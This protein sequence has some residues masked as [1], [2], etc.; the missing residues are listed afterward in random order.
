[1]VSKAS[2]CPGGTRPGRGCHRDTQSWPPDPPCPESPR[3]P[4]HPPACAPP[5]SLAP[6]QP[7]ADVLHSQ[8]Q[9]E[10]AHVEAAH[11]WW[12]SS[13]QA[14]PGERV[15]GSPRTAV[16]ELRVGSP[17]RA[18]QERV[19][20]TASVR[21]LPPGPLFRAQEPLQ[22][23]SSQGTGPGSEERTRAVP[24][25]SPAR[26]SRLRPTSGFYFIPVLSHY[27]TSR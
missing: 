23:R 13:L 11:P 10:P 7:G 14:D 3:L 1:M 21:Y 8:S 19:N 5:G 16:T 26:N 20:R 27:I 25:R 9:A 24:P 6:S 4:E 22:S 12:V 15:A 17:S 18:S 2:G